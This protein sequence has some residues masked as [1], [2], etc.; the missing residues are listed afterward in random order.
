MAHATHTIA[1]VNNVITI[2]A[3]TAEAQANTA[4]TVTSFGT[5][6]GIVPATTTN[7]VDVQTLQDTFIIDFK[8][9]DA[10]ASISFEFNSGLTQAQAVAAI[11]AAAPTG[12]TGVTMVVDNTFDIGNF[13]LTSGDTRIKF[14]YNTAGD[15][16]N[17]ATDAA[18]VTTG[19]TN[20]TFAIRLHSTN[21]V[22][23]VTEGVDAVT[24]GTLD[25]WSVTIDGTEYTG[26]FSTIAK[27]LGG[28]NANEQAA[29][30]SRVLNIDT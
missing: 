9:T 14:T 26:T 8:G 30:I 5:A 23:T 17:T 22:T 29:E 3:G 15:D 20:G 16:T 4:A 27:P 11:I 7:G 1:A 21:A 10:P 28:L 2:T 6:S 12:A 19:L 25:T 18:S 13:A 24:T